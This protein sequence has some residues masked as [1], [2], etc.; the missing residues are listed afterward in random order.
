MKIIIDP[1]LFTHALKALK[2]MNNDCVLS[3][4]EDKLFA[5]LVD[6]SLASLVVLKISK[7]DFIQYDIEEPVDIGVDISKL[8]SF[9]A[10]LKEPVEIEQ[11]DGKLIITSGKFGANMS[12][13][14]VSECPKRPRKCVFDDHVSLLSIPVQDLKL[15]IK[16]ATNSSEIL[17]KT[18]EKDGTFEVIIEDGTDLY[19]T[20]FSKN[21]L[22]DAVIGDAEVNASHNL[23]E[24]I[25]KVIPSKNVTIGVATEYVIKFAAQ[26]GK[27]S[28][29]TFY[30]APRIVKE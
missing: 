11:E 23:L 4:E 27:K 18:T 16:Q 7:D 17:L 12:T 14:S 10:T 25:L 19:P 15:A 24:P 3:F 13:V 30:L 6:P 9:V 20:T 8:L 2:E 5:V 26:L 22:T 29:T 21:E 1:A 28:S